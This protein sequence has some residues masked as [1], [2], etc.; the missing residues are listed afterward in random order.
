MFTYGI[1]TKKAIYDGIARQSVRLFGILRAYGN[2]SR[3]PEKNE[4]VRMT[5]GLVSPAGR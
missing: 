3:V 2:R 4:A 1:R 5:D